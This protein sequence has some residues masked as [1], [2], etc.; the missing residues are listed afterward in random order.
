VAEREGVVTFKSKPVTLLGPEIKVGQ[1][2]PDFK[3]LDS[4]M[5]E[6]SL[7]QSQGK[8]RLLSVVYSLETPVCDL[9]TQTF[10]EQSGKF[11][12]VVFFTI[13][14]DLPFTQ[15]RYRNEHNIRNL[16]FL[17]D[18]REASFG[19]A[20]GLLIKENRLLARAIIIIDADNLVRY[21]EYVKEVTHAPDYDKA[22]EA[23]TKITGECVGAD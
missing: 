18:Y 21:V 8:V 10:E 7:S 15:A 14:M 9:Q 4:D 6:V 3:I 22:V 2:A 13:S 16:R 1:R 19:T 17:S 11:S 5:K 12:K 23:L 20:Y